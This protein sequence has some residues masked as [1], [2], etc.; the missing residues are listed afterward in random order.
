MKVLDLC[1]GIGGFTIG[2]HE[3]G[4]ETVAFCEIEPYCQAILKKHW[5]DIPIYNDVRDITAE[6]LKSDGIVPTV[7]VGGYPCQPFSYAGQRRGD[8]DDRHLWP[9]IFRIVKDIRP[10]WCIFENV[11]GHVTMG[12]DTVLSDLEAENYATRAFII[13]ACGVDAKHKRD[14]VWIIAKYVGDTNSSKRYRDNSWQSEQEEA[15]QRFE[16]R[17]ENVADTGSQGLQGH[18]RQGQASQ[19]GQP[20]RHTP[21]CGWWPTEPNV[22]RVANGVPAR[23][24]RIKALGNAVVPQIPQVIGQVIMEMVDDRISEQGAGDR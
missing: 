24:H 23:S 11:A 10:T 2:L 4:F 7:I 3:A 21:K 14:R 5:P 16:G 12:I 18:V 8:K 17:C 20:Q 1:S 13:P 6:R 9:E 22:G 19:K 15:E